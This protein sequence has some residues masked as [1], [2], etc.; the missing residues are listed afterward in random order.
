MVR[1][2]VGGP[3]LVGQDRIVKTIRLY[4]TARFVTASGR[5]GI[6]FAQQPT[7]GYWPCQRG[8]PFRPVPIRIRIETERQE[9]ENVAKQRL[10]GR[11]NNALSSRSLPPSDLLYACIKLKAKNLAFCLREK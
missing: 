1:S 2:V 4:Q 3:Y 6:R 10:P 11:T 5:V 7:Y 8:W 9:P